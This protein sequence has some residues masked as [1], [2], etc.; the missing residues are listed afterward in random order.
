MTTKK[1][2]R[3]SDKNIATEW[4]YG[5]D[6]EERENIEKAWRN[7]TYITDI[8]KGIIDRKLEE[9]NQDRLDDYSNPNWQLV[10]VDKNGQIRALNLIK[11]LLP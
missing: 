11:A 2:S 3:Q 6:Q 4:F 9:L 7:S 1:R 5:A 10:R 8:L